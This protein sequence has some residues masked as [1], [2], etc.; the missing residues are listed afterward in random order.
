MGKAVQFLRYDA[1]LLDEPASNIQAYVDNAPC[2]QLLTN[3]NAGTWR[4]RHLRVRSTVVTDS[5]EKQN[6]TISLVPGAIELADLFTKQLPAQRLKQLREMCGLEPLKSDKPVNLLR[7]L[8]KGIR[9]TNVASFFESWQTG[10]CIQ[11]C[12]QG[13][14]S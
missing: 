9:Y 8:L 10:S 5:V 1:R 6:L 2:V 12:S 11:S 4:T 14:T 7:M 13:F 3:P